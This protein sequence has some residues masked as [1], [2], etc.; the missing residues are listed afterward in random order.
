MWPGAAEANATGFS[1]RP[2][3]ISQGCGVVSWGGVWSQHSARHPR[4]MP[5]FAGLPRNCCALVV[6]ARSQARSIPRPFAAPRSGASRDSWPQGTAAER[7]RARERDRSLE[8]NQRL[9]P[10]GAQLHQLHGSFRR[11]SSTSAPA[12]VSL[13]ASCST[14]TSAP[15]PRLA[16]SRVQAEISAGVMPIARRAFSASTR[17]GPRLRSR[18]RHEPS[19][20]TNDSRASADSA[21][22]SRS[23]TRSQC[24]Q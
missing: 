5:V 1:S 14:S 8:R 21:E 18:T 20:C 11:T 13:S 4:A 7:C 2:D 24:L 22:P 3:T 6:A 16:P 19:S 10:A 17:W 15:S 12:E 9:V 23:S